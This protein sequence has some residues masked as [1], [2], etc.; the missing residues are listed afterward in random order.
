M[1][2]FSTPAVMSWRSTGPQQE[3]ISVEGCLLHK[4]CLTL[5]FWL[6][7]SALRLA[8]GGWQAQFETVFVSVPLK[9]TPARGSRSRTLIGCETRLLRGSG[10]EEG[11]SGPAVCLRAAKH[12]EKPN[13][14][15]GV[16]GNGR[17]LTSPINQS[18]IE[19]ATGYLD[20]NVGIGTTHVGGRGG[21]S[22]LL[23]PPKTP[24][25]TLTAVALQSATQAQSK[26]K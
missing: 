5:L 19:K 21:F 4:N 12:V 25:D 8:V 14:L 10:V 26:L 20:T 11:P 9:R 15:I 24:A 18:A 2:L 17:Y 3:Q 23:F 13:G 16:S 7:Y 6:L 22:S 1:L